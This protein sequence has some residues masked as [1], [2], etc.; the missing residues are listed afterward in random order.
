MTDKT[1][2]RHD[3]G[4]GRTVPFF[5]S[6][7]AA[8]LTLM[9]SA[10][11]AA[12]LYFAPELIAGGAQDVADLSRFTQ[13][14]RQPAGTYDVEIYLNNRFV[15]QRP[16]TFSVAD[17][18]AHN[19]AAAA[20]SAQGQ[21]APQSTHGDN[22]VG[23]GG[24][25]EAS[26][27][28]EKDRENNGAPAVRDIHDDTGLMACLNK[29]ALRDLGVSINAFPALAAVA[30][31]ACVSPGRYIP[32]AYTAFDFQKMR[33][34]ISIP[35]AA[36]QSRPRGW[37]P[38]EQ[39]DEGVNAALLSYRFSGSDNKGR[40]SDSRNH[41][42]SLTSGLNLGAW[43]LRDNST[44]RDYSSRYGHERR[45]QHLNTY[46]RRTVVPWQSELTLGDSTTNGQ[47]FD[48][49]GYRGVQLASDDSML[50]DTRRGFAPVIKGTAQG[51][52]QVSIRQNGHV[53]YQTFVPPGAF[54]IDDL[55]PVSSGG[56]LVVTVTEADGGTQVFTVP[57]SSVPM[58]QREGV[59]KYGVTAGHYRNSSDRYTD[60]AF[61]Q[62]SVLWGLP[63]NLTTYGGVQLSDNYRAAALG[64]GINLGAW[65]ALSADVTQANSTLADGSDH[66][67]QSLRFLYGRSLNQL[68]TTFQ[69]AGYR[70]STQGFH[71]LDETALKGMRGWLTDGQEV[72]AEGR[73]VKRP[74]TDYY[75]LY[76]N[77][78]ER[79]Q[80]NISQRL[81]SLGSLYL[82]G[83]HQTYWSGTDASDSLQAGFSGTVGKV[84]YT[85]SHSYTRVNGQ[86]HADQTTWLSLS[87]PLDAWLSPGDIT[88]RR[89]PLWAT[90]S[91]G[92]DADGRLTQQTGLSGTALAENNLS[93]SV[94][95]GYGRDAGGSGNAS[96]N[97]QGT[98]GNTSAGYS[99][100]RNY[101][102][103][104]Y[105]AAGGAVL[106][107]GGLTLGQPL[108]DTNV[109]VAAPGAAG[110]PVE[111][112]NGIRTDWRGYTVV[113]YASVY[114]QNRVA[115]D[116]SQL[117]DYTEIDNTVT[118]VVPTRGALVKANFKARSGARALL[119]L[120]RG[121]RPL[122]FGATV[123]SGDNSGI[124]GD[125]GQVYLSGLPNAGVLTA[126][127]GAQPDQ[128]CKVHYR[129]PETN[130]QTPVIQMAARCE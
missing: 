41:Y 102:Q 106:H 84:S 25:E 7:L 58:L 64:A 119:T 44:W 101:R 126:Q 83:T 27:S 51:N 6:P 16:V 76:N 121:G 4:R 67:G 21:T 23:K 97:Y 91:M 70:Y 42:L 69:L 96:V 57:Y 81:G 56:D 78:R 130:P 117:D 2:S 50:P 52:A 65:G 87:V 109:L 48:A 95:Q 74:Y 79:L 32:Q 17:G 82:S 62:A 124:V 108:G 61:A 54:T 68:G 3:A 116:S 113:P 129:L 46:A 45:W 24:D 60:P 103:V 127:W 11:A 71:T 100:N 14:G 111:N 28:A 1:L 43:R 125:D 72:D 85:L 15:V 20:A 12:E 120:T 73:P 118:R 122:P 94:A 89:H 59:V 19:T 99:Y 75:N 36:L 123:S 40:Y 112:G 80:V 66:Q 114:R 49:V 33:L 30:D 98:Y 8:A 77:K 128:Q 13:A 5:L 10:P 105:G 37:I 63:H 93:W 29:K 9:I 104:N 26:P 35:Q 88:D 110:V 38:P 90:A 47:V 115:L 55:Y 22:R 18:E 86:P 39:W 92:R 31:D 34:D 53:I 107:G